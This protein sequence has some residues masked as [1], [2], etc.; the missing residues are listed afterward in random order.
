MFPRIVPVGSGVL[1]SLGILLSASTAAAATIL[2]LD[3]HRQEQS[4]S[5]EIATL[6]MA[7]GVHDIDVSEA[8]LISRLP[9][10]PTPKGNGIWGDPNVGFV[11]RINGSMLR[12]GYGVYWDPIA[13]VGN[14]YT[15]TEVLRHSSASQLAR[16]IADGN[17]VIIWGYYGRRAVYSWQTPTGKDIK[18]VDGEH[19]RVVY[20]FEGTVQNPTRFYL[21]DPVTGTFSWSTAELMHNWSSLNH[22]AVVIKPSRQ[23]VRTS[24]SGQVWELNTKTKTRHLVPTW[25]TFVARGGSS[26]NIKTVDERVLETYQRGQDIS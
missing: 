13:K 8:E 21:A 10:D 25:E 7:L 23:W 15:D 2:P 16:H 26:T 19:T 20:G 4:L 5:C 3:F 24:D 17:P 12:T 14:H 22:M 9:F 1:I 6:K 11:G 18:A